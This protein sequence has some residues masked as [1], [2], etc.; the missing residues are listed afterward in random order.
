MEQTLKSILRVSENGAVLRKKSSNR[1]VVYNLPSWTPEM[2]YAIQQKYP[3][4]SYYMQTNSESLS[5][6]VLILH[7]PKEHYILLS[8]LSLVFLLSYCFFLYKKAWVMFPL[9]P[10]LFKI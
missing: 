10:S 7:R 2:E 3:D 5:G 8:F 4:I 1:Y 9:I 6:I